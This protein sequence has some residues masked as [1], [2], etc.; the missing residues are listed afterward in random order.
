VH[1]LTA[2]V[3][4]WTLAACMRTVV[5]PVAPAVLVELTAASASAKV[6]AT[7]DDQPAAPYEIERLD[8]RRMR[9]YRPF[10]VVVST[11]STTF[12]LADPVRATL[13]G[14]RLIVEGAAAKRVDVSL[15]AVTGL[16]LRQRRLDGRR[17]AI[18]V[19]IGLGVATL[20]V[21]VLGVLLMNSAPTH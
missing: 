16:E 20:C 5:T 2:V 10:G 7:T 8:G 12:S 15:G 11:R 4:A 3:V 1:I 13:A 19:G 21:G 14:D 17:T 18:N 6:P 9:L